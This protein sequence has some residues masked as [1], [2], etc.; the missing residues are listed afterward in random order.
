MPAGSNRRWPITI[1]Q[2]IGSE[3]LVRG[4]LQPRLGILVSNL[5]FERNYCD[6]GNYSIGVR[7]DLTASNVRLWNNTFGRNHRYG[8]IARPSQSG[9]TWDRA[10]NVYGDSLRPVVE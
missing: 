1:R 6:G 9:I 7:T 8:V 4:A 2:G 10:T 3:L 5:L